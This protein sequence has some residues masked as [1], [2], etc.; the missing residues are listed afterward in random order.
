M[1]AHALILIE[2]QAWMSYPPLKLQ[3]IGLSNSTL[4]LLRQKNSS[5]F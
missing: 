5:I 1:H 2:L 4:E 3:K